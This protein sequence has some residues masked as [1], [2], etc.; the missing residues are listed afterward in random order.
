M[1]ANSS[2]QNPSEILKSLDAIGQAH[3]SAGWNADTSAADKDRF[4][5]QVKKL[6]TAYPGGVKAYVDGASV[7]GPLECEFRSALPGCL[8]ALATVISGFC[9]CG[10]REGATPTPEP[11]P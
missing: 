4:F 5:T 1:G 11:E 8:G 9:A 10:L 2:R 3:L 6:E 7:P